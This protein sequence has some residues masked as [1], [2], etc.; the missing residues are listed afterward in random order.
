MIEVITMRI[1]IDEAIRDQIT[2]KMPNVLLGTEVRVETEMKTILE[3]EVETE[4]IV[5]L[6]QGEERSLTPDLIPG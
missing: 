6:C 5:G 2:D 4:I 1:I 3:V